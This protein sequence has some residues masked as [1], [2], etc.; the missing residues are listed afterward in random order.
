[1]YADKMT[2]SMQRAID[3]TNRRRAKQRKYNEENGIIPISIHKAIHD[4]TEEFSAKAV[5]EMKGEYKVKDAG[6][7][8]RNELRKIIGEMEKQM[9]EAAKNLD[10]ER[11][12]VGG[13]PQVTVASARHRVAPP[14]HEPEL[15]QA[16][17]ASER[18]TAERALPAGKDLLDVRARRSK[19]AVAQRPRLSQFALAALRLSATRA[20]QQSRAVTEA[21][22]AGDVGI[23]LR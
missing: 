9:K 7:I 13:E 22:E 2:D 1:M 3:E 12:A 20:L 15:R 10:F 23:D 11:A 21:D 4:L 18:D 16:I 19:E 6:A 17:A 5:S 14:V 8:P